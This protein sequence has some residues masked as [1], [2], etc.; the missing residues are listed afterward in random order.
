MDN[1]PKSEVLHMH[2]KLQEIVDHTAKKFGL[3][4]YHLKNH[5]IF[6]EQDSFNKSSYLLSMEWFPNE[7][8]ETDE[9]FNPAGTA[10]IEMDIHNKQLKRMAFVQEVTYANSILTT[11]DLEETIEWIE[12][13]TGLEFGRQFKLIDDE[14]GEIYF[15]AAVDNV[16]V[17]P[18]GSIRMQFNELDQ[19]V[20]FS[21]DG[22]FPDE[23]QINWEPFSLTPAITDPIASEQCQLLE[24]PVEDEEKWL[25]VYGAATIFVTNNG[26]RLL[27]FN[28]VEANH[29]FIKENYRLEW[30]QPLN[31]SFK[32][33]EIDLSLEVSVA[34]ALSNET[35][36]DTRPLTKQDQLRAINGMR[37]FLQR[38]FPHDSG[39]WKLVGIWREH[40][41]IFAELKPSFHDPRVIERKM[42]LIMDKDNFEVLNFSDN[43]VVLD[44]LKD[45]SDAEETVVTPEDAFEKLR[46]Y[47]DVNPVYVLDKATAKYTLCGKIDCS[48][49]VDAITG[50]VISLD[51]L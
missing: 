20:L 44:M 42:Q 51:E 10:I 30:E 43:H 2:K 32:P 15:Q 29:S 31:E 24:I 23:T 9:D 41:Y 45:F 7:L 13:E 16:A 21:I 38:E 19:L 18:S 17:Y 37:Q 8:E 40:G 26:E 5:H 22:D 46:N 36:P 34:E 47:I 33:R 11:F 14:N 1:S 3:E 39:E 48:Y 25:P 12:E 27:T 49:G 4:N 6:R 50:E 28:E 35:H